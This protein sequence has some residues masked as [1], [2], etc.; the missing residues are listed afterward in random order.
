MNSSSM[1][2]DASPIDIARLPTPDCDHSHNQSA[3]NHVL[4]DKNYSLRIIIDFYI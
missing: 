2:I 3:K 1:S 4:K